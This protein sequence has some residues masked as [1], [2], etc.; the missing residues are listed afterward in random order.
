MFT[1]DRTLIM[2]MNIRVKWLL[3]ILFYFFQ[4]FYNLFSDK[5]EIHGVCIPFPKQQI[6]D[7]P[8]LKEF[9]EE[10]FKCWIRENAGY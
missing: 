6:R 7:F 9:A 2:Q 4:I 1:S 3:F 8:K 10:N 5:N